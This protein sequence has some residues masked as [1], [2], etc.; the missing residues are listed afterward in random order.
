[1]STEI[2]RQV[3]DIEAMNAALLEEVRR[4][5]C[6]ILAEGLPHTKKI[7][8]RGGYKAEFTL[9]HCS[10]TEAI[11]LVN[12]TGPGNYHKVL[13]A[14]L[15]TKPASSLEGEIQG[16]TKL[17]IGA[18]INV[19]Y[20][21]VT[22]DEIGTTSGVCEAGLVRCTPT[23]LERSLIWAFLMGL[24]FTAF[25]PWVWLIV[26]IISLLKQRIGAGILSIILL[27]TT[28]A[29]Y[30]TL[31]KILPIPPIPLQPQNTTLY[32]FATLTF[33]LYFPDIYH[34]ITTR[35]LH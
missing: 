5:S 2:G 19:S 7:T 24:I 30:N 29:A 32:L 23:T 27:I 31:Q 3:K 6:D 12:V 11:Y 35:H 10:G 15:T 13:T 33:L 17:R 28:L 16:G 9:Q 4:R 14:T 21:I 1:M 20:A 8:L 18:T 26:A 34:R 25:T 22:S